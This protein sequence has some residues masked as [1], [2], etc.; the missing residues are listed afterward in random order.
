MHRS[1]SHLTNKPCKLFTVL[2]VVAKTLTYAQKYVQKH[3]Q[4]EQTVLCSSESGIC[5]VSIYKWNQHTY[6]NRGHWQVNK[7]SVTTVLIYLVTFWICF[8]KYHPILWRWIRPGTEKVSAAVDHS[9]QAVD[10]VLVITQ[11]SCVFTTVCWF[12]SGIRQKVGYS[13]DLPQKKPLNIGAYLEHS[14]WIRW[15]FFF[16]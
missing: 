10:H 8:L 9:V 14:L 11:G 2:H 1:A 4:L 3:S 6:R 13:T 12:V 5:V 16:S 15:F 7:W